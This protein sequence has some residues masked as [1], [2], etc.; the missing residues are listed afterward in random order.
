MHCSRF[1]S[2]VFHSLL[3][4]RFNSV[5]TIIVAQV[6]RTM[7]ANYV[8]RWV[9]FRQPLIAI[10]SQESSYVWCSKIDRVDLPW[11]PIAWFDS[12]DDRSVF[13]RF[14]A[15]SQYLSRLAISCPAFSVNP[16]ISLRAIFRLSFKPDELDSRTNRQRDSKKQNR[17][18]CVYDLKIWRSRLSIIDLSQRRLLS[19][20]YYD[21][22]K[23]K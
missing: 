5:A 4:Q 15:L 18:N 20:L 23:P 21:C 6:G 12:G 9:N 16:K 13:H 8:Y 7:H 10:I 22:N 1:C 17:P 19:A 11:H 2:I 3:Q 14:H